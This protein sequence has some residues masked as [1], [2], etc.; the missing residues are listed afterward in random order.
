M[1]KFILAALVAGTAATPAFAQ[2]AGTAASFRIEAIGGYE[3]QEVA[4]DNKSGQTYG[5]GLGYDFQT[6]GSSV[7]GIEAEA[8]DSNTDECVKGATVATDELCAE[9]G[10][11]LYVGARFG[12]NIGGNTILYAKAG[13]TNARVKIDYDDGIAGTTG[14]FE[15]G[16]N[17][18]GLRAG[19]GVQF[20]F[21]TGA[22]A[23]LE[24]RYSDYEE[25]FKKHQGVVGVGLRF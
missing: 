7:F 5:V 9:F 21:G 2:D 11:D 17:L 6:N 16:R 10:R 25:G 18:D 4:E 23:K 24:Y 8:S 19:G 14:D 12:S 13:Y 20:G 1:R 15:A 22:Y 3:S